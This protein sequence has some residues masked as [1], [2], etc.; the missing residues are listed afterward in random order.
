MWD[1]LFTFE[2]TKFT[3]HYIQEYFTQ[4]L[5]ILISTVIKSLDGCHHNIS[6]W[7]DITDSLD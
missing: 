7:T 2:C 6:K 3:S 5:F 1:F 4:F